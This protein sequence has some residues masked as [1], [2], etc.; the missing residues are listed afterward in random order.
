MYKRKSNLG[1]TVQDE[2]VTHP[3]ANISVLSLRHISPFKHCTVLIQRPLDKNEDLIS[4]DF[5]FY[6]SPL[7]RIVVDLRRARP[8]KHRPNSSHGRFLCPVQIKLPLRLDDDG[9]SDVKVIL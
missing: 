6:L 2:I 4:D 7:A 8:V 3:Y 5:L 1:C 9:L